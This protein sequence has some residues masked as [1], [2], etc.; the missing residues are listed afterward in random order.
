MMEQ[1]L[2]RLLPEG[3]ECCFP[4]ELTQRFCSEVTVTFSHVSL[5]KADH[6]A[7]V[8]AR[9]FPRGEVNIFE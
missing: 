1:S 9:L 3:T 4:F 5:A 7:D 8:N 6:K 2:S